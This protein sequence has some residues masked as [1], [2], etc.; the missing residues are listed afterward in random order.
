M[1]QEDMP[2]QSVPEA[3][4][5]DQGKRFFALL[6]YLT[7]GIPDGAYP[8]LSQELGAAEGAIK[9]ALSRP[10]HQRVPQQNTLGQAASRSA[11]MSNQDSG[12]TG[13][14]SRGEI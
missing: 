5:T 12:E 2:L 10:A 6:P 14:N 11:A 8:A 7:A 13:E 3:R 4:S 1:N 9:T